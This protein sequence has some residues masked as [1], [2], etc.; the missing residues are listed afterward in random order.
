M[1]RMKLVAGLLMIPVL[2][3]AANPHFISGPD[4]SSQNGSLQVCGTIA[5]LGNQNVTIELTAIA[6][7]TCINKGGN[8]PP[9]Q[10]QT[11]SGRVSNLRVENGRVSFCVTTNRVQNP[12]PDG[13]R[14]SVTFSNAQLTVIQGG[15]VVLRESIST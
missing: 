13:M 4:V 11:L 10:R 8:P 14:F 2:A 12:C 6:N 7:V 9:G 1:R 5:G 15:R 3:L